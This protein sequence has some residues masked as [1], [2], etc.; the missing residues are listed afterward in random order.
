MKARWLYPAVI[1]LVSISGSSSFAEEPPK[2]QLFLL[3]QDNVK[4]GREEAYIAAGQEANEMF[5]KAGFPYMSMAYRHSSTFYTIVPLDSFA[6]LDKGMEAFHKVEQSAGSEKYKEVVK[7]VNQNILSTSSSILVARPDLS[8]EPEDPL[9]NVDFTKTYNSYIATYHFKPECCF[10][11]EAV[12]K[13]MLAM[14]K[15]KKVRMAYQVCEVIFGQE[16]PAFSVVFPTQDLSQFLEESK[17]AM[18]QMGPECA[19]MRKKLASL[20]QRIDEQMNVA[21][22]PEL[23]YSPA[24]Q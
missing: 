18:E 7:K 4:V 3:M 8:Y 11:I 15:D 13:E 12:F 2:P 21:F 6:A 16:T 1:A 19:E 24:E 23:C 9:F 5:K 17:K 20:V 22:L 14:A 10:D